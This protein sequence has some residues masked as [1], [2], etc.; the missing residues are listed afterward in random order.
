MGWQRIPKDDT[1]RQA[2]RQKTEAESPLWPHDETVM[3]FDRN[4]DLGSG[5]IWSK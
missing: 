3:R 5:L 2:Q 1:Q 4:D